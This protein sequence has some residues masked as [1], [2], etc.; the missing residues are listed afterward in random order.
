MVTS[1]KVRRIIVA[2]GETAGA[3]V[4]ALGIKTVEVLRTLSPGVPALRTVGAHPLALVLKSG[5]FGGPDF[6]AEAA[7][8]LE[9]L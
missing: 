5:N 4:D 9:T 6:F 7:A 3:V 2:G 1:R 8:Y